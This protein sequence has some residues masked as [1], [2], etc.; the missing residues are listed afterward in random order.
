MTMLQSLS[1]RGYSD[2]FFVPTSDG[3]LVLPKTS[4]EYA[5]IEEEMME[6]LEEC[7]NRISERRQ[8]HSPRLSSSEC[9]NCCSH[10]GT[11]SDEKH[12]L[13]QS[14]PKTNY[15]SC[16]NCLA[17]RIRELPYGERRLCSE[18]EASSESEVEADLEAESESEYASGCGWRDLAVVYKATIKKTLR[19]YR[20]NKPPLKKH[21]LFSFSREE[22]KEK[23]SSEQ[24]HPGML[25]QDGASL[26][27]EKTRVTLKDISISEKF[28]FVLLAKTA[29]DIVGSL[30]LFKHDDKE[31]CFE[32]PGVLKD[33]PIS[34][35]RVLGKHRSEPSLV[36]E[37]IKKM[38][39]KTIRCRCKEIS[40]G[41]SH[42]AGILPSLDMRGE[43]RIE[44]FCLYAG[45]KKKTSETLK[46]INRKSVYL[47]RVGKMNLDGYAAEFLSA[48][49]LDGGSEMETL[50]LSSCSMPDVASLFK[51]NKVNLG[52]VKAIRATDYAISAL[53]F[54]VFH[55]ENVFESVE[56]Y[57]YWRMDIAELFKD[58]RICLGKVNAIRFVKYAV[59]ALPFFVFHE[60]GKVFVLESAREL[61]IT[62]L[63]KDKRVCLGKVKTMAITD[64]AIPAL[65][66][67]V[68]HEDNV[69]EL[70]KLRPCWQTSISSHLKD[71]KNKSIDIGK[72]RKGGLL[73]PARIKQ[74]LKYVVVDGQG[75]PTGT[76]P[77]E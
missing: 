16:H 59:L 69:F 28:F 15:F 27:T 72:V 4:H 61:N 11:L 48:L 43:S 3:I 62:E 71:A 60:E 66:F 18:C 32:G 76:G 58:N 37:N 2:T 5:Q 22:Q 31:C 70:V 77:L 75:N 49:T 63:F 42:F 9:V 64:Y 41:N 7:R 29:V 68:F 24:K 53:P 55:E 25:D 47:G 46:E 56:L 6:N 10:C 74:K 38:P 35:I 21:V 34:L 14:C 40:I 52:K 36:L 51:D 44:S 73:A 67:L 45:R 26:L 33:E 39:A 17:G 23:P 20:E 19:K 12:F 57:S 65:P 1:F 8:R 54:L 13:F 50:E 30:S